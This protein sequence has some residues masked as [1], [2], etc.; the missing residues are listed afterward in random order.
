MY[1]KGLETL[2]GRPVLNHEFGLNAEGLRREARLGIE[3]LRKRIGTSEEFKETAVRKSIE[4]LGDYCRSNGKQ[5][6]NVDLME[7]S[8]GNEDGVDRSGSDGWMR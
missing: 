1:H 2:V 8:D 5:F 4:M 3:R 6:L 7:T